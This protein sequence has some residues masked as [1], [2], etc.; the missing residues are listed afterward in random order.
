MQAWEA[1]RSGL[2]DKIREISLL[3]LYL[4]WK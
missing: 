2:K 4:T 1:K 3:L